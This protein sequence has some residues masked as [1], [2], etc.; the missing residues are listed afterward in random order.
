MQFSAQAL[1]T[2][3]AVIDLETTGLSPQSD[4]I[5]EI[6]VIQLD[7]D[8]QQTS[9]W[10]TLIKPVGP[11]QGTKIHGI[12]DDDVQDAPS[13]ATAAK[14]LLPLLQGRILVAH[15]AN[16][17]AAFLMQFKNI[18]P[19]FRGLS[20][21]NFV[22]TM[23][24]SYIYTPPGSHSLFNL[25]RRLELPNIPRIQ[26]RALA[27]AAVTA[28]LFRWLFAREEENS[29]LAET[30]LSRQGTTIFPASWKYTP[31]FNP[32]SEQLELLELS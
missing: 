13:A 4:E 16:F 5:L 23:E 21:K 20:R 32:A 2:K 24:Q 31:A 1:Q 26:H 14:D 10:S 12:T 28:S 18:V 15:N 17:D 8:L 30:A 7:A 19:A 25:A 29:R 3:Y 6:A 11:V 9:Q 27:D 22:C